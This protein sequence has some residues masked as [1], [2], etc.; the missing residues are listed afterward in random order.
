MD[1]SASRP[2]QGDTG[3]A[4]ST[5]NGRAWMNLHVSLDGRSAVLDYRDTVTIT[6]ATARAVSS[7]RQ[8]S[9]MERTTTRLTRWW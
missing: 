1:L 8:N 4:Y 5:G 9:A 7:T 6:I 3:G 2:I